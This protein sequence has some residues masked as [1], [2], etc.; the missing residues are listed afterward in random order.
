MELRK[1]F[2][3]T[4]SYTGKV[5]P[6]RVD[7]NGYIRLN[8]MVEY[9]PGKRIDNWLTLK[10]TK[11]FI[12]TLE[13]FLTPLDSR[14]L[15]VED[16]G[17]SGK[18]PKG[19]ESIK[20][21]SGKYNGGTYASYDLA[22]EFAMWLSPEFKLN[23][24]RAYRDG[25]QTKKD[26]NIKRIMTAENF[27]FMQESKKNEIERHDIKSPFAYSNEAKLVNIIVL[28]KHEKGIRNNLSEDKLEMLSFVEVKNA[29]FID[30]DMPYEERKTKLQ[31]LFNLKYSKELIDG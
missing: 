22:M 4:V 11:E 31:E 12:I 6:I 13:K 16:F 17:K 2:E 5:N 3:M 7:S 14:E 9:F 23:V 10:A 19:L 25:T 27:K 8:D 15:K 30:L 1:A 21:R 18:P 24:I 29:A 20:T 26:W 28:G